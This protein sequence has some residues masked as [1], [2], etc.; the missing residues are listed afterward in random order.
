MG[1][2]RIDFFPGSAR[3]GKQK[4]RQ[5]RRTASPR[6]QPRRAR[7]GARSAAARRATEGPPEADKP[8]GYKPNQGTRARPGGRGE[9]EDERRA[10]PPE[11]RAKAARDGKARRKEREARQ[12]TGTEGQRQGH[13][14]NSGIREG[15]TA[16]RGRKKPLLS[17]GGPGR[18]TE[19]NKRRQGC[20]PRFA[21]PTK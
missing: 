6:P 11:G 15:R 9:G 1:K 10:R 12:G 8:R 3:R 5:G 17:G 2:A 7:T 14:K 20:R 18:T 13:Q 4:N 21:P 16:A 19:A